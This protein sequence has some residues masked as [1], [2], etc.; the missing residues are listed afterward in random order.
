MGL[1]IILIKF[2]G[3][4][5][6]KSSLDKWDPLKAHNAH[7]VHRMWQI[8]SMIN[9]KYMYII[10][11]DSRLQSKKNCFCPANIL[12]VSAGHQTDQNWFGFRH[13]FRFKMMLNHL[14]NSKYSVFSPKII[15]SSLFKFKSIEWER[16]RTPR[17]NRYY[18]CVMNWILTRNNQCLLERLW[19]LSIA[20]RHVSFFV[21]SSSHRCMS[22][23]VRACLRMCMCVYKYACASSPHLV[24]FAVF[25]FLHC[26]SSFTMLWNKNRFIQI[27]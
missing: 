8:M 6:Q 14:L 18:V 9:F 20:V 21:L 10:L 4:L 3:Y 13:Y 22:M 26:R 1:E 25:E 11:S 27:Y 12:V 2:C 15:T 17:N 19:L 24:I 7:D 16:E 5:L 23:C